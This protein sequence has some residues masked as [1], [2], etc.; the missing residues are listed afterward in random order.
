[1]LW[2]YRIL[3][4]LLVT[5]SSY[6]SGQDTIKPIN[7]IGGKIAPKSI[8]HS[9]YGLFFA[10]NMMYRHTITVYDGDFE[11]IKTISD[12]VRLKDFGHKEYDGF[13]R[14]APVECAFSHNGKYAWVSNYQMSGIDAFLNPGCDECSG[15]GKYDSSFV[16]KI[17]TENLEIINAIKVGS[18]P[19]FLAVSPNNDYLFVSNWSSGNVSIIDLTTELEVRRIKVGRFPRGIVF[20]PN[21]KLAYVAVMGSNKIACIDY[22]NFS[23]ETISGVGKSPRH[24]CID[25][26]GE[27]LYVSL[28]GEGNVKQIN[29]NTEVKQIIPT[30]S[31]PRTMAIQGKWLYV[32]N[33]GSNNYCK[34]NTESLRIEN[35]GI[36]SS[37]P[38]GITIDAINGRLWVACYSGKID[39]FND[40]DLKRIDDFQTVQSIKEFFKQVSNMFIHPPYTS[41]AIKTE[42][43][44]DNQQQTKSTN[45]T[46][47][48]K[49]I[50]EKSNA[51]KIASEAKPSIAEKGYHVI[52]G[53]FRNETNAI[54]TTES[55]KKRGFSASYFKNKELYSCS[56]F[57]S[58]EKEEAT[59][60]AA[61]LTE[62]GISNWI[63]E[64]K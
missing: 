55:Y 3:S 34:I 28:N 50:N 51:I 18:V 63:M 64:V 38:I 39:V 27:N 48:V 1:M 53:S 15:E 57:F 59:Q 46:S 23:T 43:L 35:V 30:G 58:P 41:I 10:Q 33:Y 49:T 26:N 12:R 6:C 56:A 11:L 61:T 45:N 22:D 4:L 19:K 29:L 17:D 42:P 13:Y 14:G 54:K 24:L 2:F 20:H 7:S 9:G 21:K 60:I 8:V 47:K 16:Y 40:P 25:D 31:L 5:Y 32:V 36:T 44:L 37:K 62:K 52:V